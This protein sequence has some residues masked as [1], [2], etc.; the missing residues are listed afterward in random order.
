MTPLPSISGD[1]QLYSAQQF[2]YSGAYYQQ[3]SPT[4]IH[5]IS[6]ATPISQ[7]DWTMPIDQQG[8]FPA[9]TLN[10]NANLFSPTPGYQLSYDSFGGGSTIDI[11]YIYI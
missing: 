3:P 9:D 4:N 6:S 11:E 1:G 7:A 2:Q 10:F 8:S 5:N